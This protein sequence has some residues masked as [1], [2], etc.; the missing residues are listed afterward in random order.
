MKPAHLVALATGVVVLLAPAGAGAGQYTVRSCDAA[1][2]T[3]G[4]NAWQVQAGSVN[5]YALCP[6][7]GGGT[8]NTRG[9]TTRM[10]GSDFASGAF[11]R[12]W[13]YAPAGTTISRLDWAG[14]AARERCYW[15]V[16]MRAQGGA[17]DA[18]LIGWPTQ[19]GTTSC[20]TA[21]DAPYV[22][23]Y[24]PPA[25]TTRLMQNTQC[26]GASC[27]NGY[28]A[29]FHTYYSA[30]TLNDFSAPSVSVGGVAEGEWVRSDR[31]ITFSAVDNIGISRAQLIVDGQPRAD[32]VNYGCDYTRPTPC[33]N[34]SG[35][36]EIPTTELS[37]GT[38]RVEVLVHDGSGTAAMAGRTIRVDNVP[39]PQVS[40]AVA[41]G[42]GWRNANG[43]SVGWS[44]PSDGG[45]PIVG[46]TWELCR[47][48]RGACSTHQLSGANPTS[49]PRFGVSSD[50][51]YE[52]RV[53]LRDQ[54]GNVA[55]L[56]DARP[57]ML[58]LD[59]ADPVVSI[60]GP[61]PNHPVQASATVNDSLSGLAGGQIELR[62]AGSSTWRELPTTVSGSRLVSQIDDERFADGSYELRAR[63]VDRAGNQQTTGVE[64]NGA[65][66]TRQLPLRIKTRLRAGRRVSRIVRRTVRRDGRK[67]VVRRRVTGFD[68]GVRVGFGRRAVIRGV[69]ANPD[70]Q[71]LEDVPI[72]VLA[73]PD[74]PRA[75][76][77][78]AAVVRTD[79]AGRF[80]YRVKGSASRT[81]RFR[82]DGTSRIR[83]T[84]TDVE[85]AV[86]ASSR[87]KLSPP[88]ILNGE[89]VT[90]AGRVR[91]GP[92]PERGKL[93]EL[94]KWTGRA[95]AP[96][97]VVRTDPRGRWRHVEPVLSVRG[98]V[99]FRLRALIPA[100]AGFPYATGRTPAR[101][102]LVQGQ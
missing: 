73:R 42:E 101:K 93:I 59:R 90:F 34:H 48:G 33:A 44:V 5:S 65:R 84:T 1:P 70:G 69:L 46:A 89:A 11:S 35:S 81:I 62:R 3:H 57:V 30:V 9:I 68:P 58:R 60:D 6:T 51:V 2:P 7:A 96:F 16:E 36:F 80:S 17:S 43:F 37:A 95:W 64:A 94:Q 72:R 27:P 15:Q 63:A 25:G 100:E 88:R 8:P 52:V 55:S 54:A 26:G 61:D 86:P 38:H 40:P 56:S 10:V 78:A 76:L 41:G 67:R 82:Y 47:L 99:T 21:I 24:W 79:S 32:A 22:A 49:I 12:W 98:L 23:T 91:G 85:V 87:F 71:P 83:P 66:A 31:L 14:R 75:G 20:G 74:L 102:L 45:S 4:P 13:F 50:G 18:R 77:A 97:R 19:P 53:V 29:T 92:I 39:P 28:G